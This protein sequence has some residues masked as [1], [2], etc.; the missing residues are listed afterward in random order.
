MGLKISPAIFQRMVDDVLREFI[1]K[2]CFVYMDDI[3]IFSASFEQHLRDLDQILSKLDKANLKINIEKCEWAKPSLKYLGYVI[4]AEGIRPDQSKIDTIKKIRFPLNL[5]ELRSF[6]GAVNFY[7]KFIKD[8]SK[9]LKPITELTKVGSCI[10]KNSSSKVSIQENPEAERAF[11]QIKEILASADLLIFPDISKPYTLTTDASNFALGAVLSQK[12]E[13]DQK[14]IQFLS[15]TLTS[16]EQKLS[17]IEKEL[18][19]IVWAVDHLRNY[20]YGN[21][22]TI[23]TDHKPLTYALKAKNHNDKLNR[24]MARLEEFDHEILYK[25]GKEN[26]VADFLSRL[27]INALSDATQHSALSDSCELIP[28]SLRPLNSF[29]NQILIKQADE[30]SYKLKILFKMYKR[31]EICLKDPTPGVLCDF[32]RSKIDN[33]VENAFNAPE[34][35]VQIIQNILKDEPQLRKKLVFSQIILNDVT[36]EDAQFELVKNEHERAHRGIQENNSK[37]KSVYFWPSMLSTIKNY[38]KTCKICKTSKYDRNPQPNVVHETPIPE[39][40]GQIIHIDIFQIFKK[41]FLT[42][43]CKLTK[44]ATV[45]PINSKSTNDVKSG[46][47]EIILKYRKPD[48]IV[49][50]NEPSFR[51]H[52]V[53]ILLRNLDINVHFI[54]P[55]HSESN[56]QIERVHSTITEILRCKQKEWDE[57]DSVQKNL[58]ATDLYNNSIHSVTKFKPVDL[59]FASIT[60]LNLEKILKDKDNLLKTVQNRIKNKQIQD[61]ERNNTNTFKTYKKGQEIFVKDSQIKAKSKPLFCKE[62]VEEDLNTTIKTKNGKII[63]KSKIRS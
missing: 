34:N 41:N 26:V 58:I 57:F 19:A 29:R 63:H 1:G 59:F 61:I 25:P 55:G 24:W 52:V 36:G 30:D 47:I 45:I 21:K 56:G 10:S 5:K 40:P 23:F 39:R 54:P 37:L 14:P 22:V 28:T 12:V 3:I 43:I 51:S 49:C 13:K 48:I 6:L 33:N 17:T 7:R 20:L 2:C 53:E 38:I 18:L 11:V 62:I 35:W 27:E 32:F 50:D 44:Y 16:A 31:H 60:V 9:I 42:S 8:C 4:S 15:R 46:L